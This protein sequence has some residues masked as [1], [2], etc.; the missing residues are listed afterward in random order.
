[1]IVHVFRHRIEQ[2]KYSKRVPISLIEKEHDWN[3]NL[4]RYVDNTPPP[5]PEDV[6]C[7]LIGGVPKAEVDAAASKKQFAKFG[8]KP[9]CVFEKLDDSRLT[10]QTGLASA[11]DV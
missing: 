2:D 6:R 10:F 7:H 9:G 4:R 11:P 3:L 5:E 1:K 8:I